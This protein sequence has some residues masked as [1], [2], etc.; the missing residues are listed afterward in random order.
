MDSSAYFALALLALGLGLLI[1]EIFI[2]SGGMIFAG[3]A[4]CLLAS[5][6]CAWDAWWES[7]R[8]VWWIYVASV[9]VLLPTVVAGALYVFP[10]TPFGRRILLEGPEPEE[11]TPYAEDEAHLS[12]LVGKRG[13]T[14]TLLTPG[15]MSVVEGQRMHCESEGMLIEPGED[16]QVI[17]VK[18]NRLVVRRISDEDETGDE[19]AG[20]AEP[21]DEP[22]LDFD[23]PPS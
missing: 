1:A 19:F 21:S 10:R 16:I 2:P 12:E 23:I 17:G 20:D 4:V 14:I 11:I 3:A 22:P 8:T 5:L 15:G 9:V 18:G 13:K 6:W 7:Y